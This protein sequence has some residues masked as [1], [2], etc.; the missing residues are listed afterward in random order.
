MLINHCFSN[1]ERHLL[2][3]MNDGGNPRILRRIVESG[4]PNNSKEYR[5]LCRD[6]FNHKSKL[7]SDFEINPLLMVTTEHG[8]D[9]SEMLVSFLDKYLGY[10]WSVADNKI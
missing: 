4:L 10:S 1:N 5:E 6:I 7:P 8:W 9:V 3:L 2:W